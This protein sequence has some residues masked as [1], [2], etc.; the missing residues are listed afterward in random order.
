MVVLPQSR[1]AVEFIK[2]GTYEGTSPCNKSRGQVPSCKLAFLI[3]NLVAGTNFGP[4][5]WA[6]S[7]IVN[8]SVIRHCLTTVMVKQRLN[9]RYSWFKVGLDDDFHKCCLKIIDPIQLYNDFQVSTDFSRPRTLVIASSSLI[10][11]RM[12]IQFQTSSIPNKQTD[13]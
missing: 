1:K 11:C 13:Q 2:V 5:D 6:R 8:Q 10:L 4:C 7:L 12:F 9:N 3:Q